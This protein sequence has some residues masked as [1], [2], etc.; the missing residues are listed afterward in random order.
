VL[1][2]IYRACDLIESVNGFNVRPFNLSKKDII[3]ISSLSLSESILDMDHEV[4]I[5]GDRISEEIELFLKS[6]GR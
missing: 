5:I 4:H 6:I 1:K 3:K 2:I